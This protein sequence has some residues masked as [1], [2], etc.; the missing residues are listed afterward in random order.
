[1]ILCCSMATSAPVPSFCLTKFRKKIVLKI[2]WRGRHRRLTKRIQDL[3]YLLDNE[4]GHSMGW[5][6]CV[7]LC[8][9]VHNNYVGIGTVGDPKLTTIENIAV[10]CQDNQHLSI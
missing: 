3:A 2:T 8:L 5:I 6:L 1:M 7:Q 10:T 4:G 9:G